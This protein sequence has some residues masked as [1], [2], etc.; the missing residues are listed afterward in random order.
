MTG[1]SIPAYCSEVID[2][3]RERGYE[4]YVVG[5]AVRDLISGKIPHDYDLASSARPEELLKIF[6]EFGFRV[7]AE[8]G[9]KHGT[10][11]VINKGEILEI[12]SFRAD[13][14][15]S[16]SRH[17][18]R[19]S[20]S[21]DIREDVKRRDFTMNA[22][23]LDSEGNVKDLVGGIEDIKNRIIRTVGDPKMRFSE[24]AL[25]IMRAL[26]FASLN[27]FDIDAN[28][29]K[30][31]YECRELLKEI[32]S[33]RIHTELTG[34]LCGRYASKV[35][36]ENVDILSVIIPELKIMEGFD[37]KS[38]YHHLDILEHTLCVL[39]NIPLNQ[40]GRRD[41]TLAYAALMHDMGKPRAFRV[42]EDGKGHMDRHPLY[43]VEISARIAAEL[44]FSNELRDNI[45]EL[46]RFHDVFVK[47]QEKSVNRLMRKLP[48]ELLSKL[49]I[50]QRADILAHSP[51]G[52]KREEI[53][54]SIIAIHDELIN[55][56]VPLSIKDLAING[57]DLINLGVKPG[58]LLGKILNVLLDKVADG[59]INNNCEDLSAFALNYLSEF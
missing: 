22:L 18:D 24:D 35:I 26:R 19:V 33:E 58:P 7:I 2:I 54:D 57:N 17:P 28:T 43:S 36:R 38:D 1:Y 29:S 32:S 34:I 23:Y 44:K 25:R 11:S 46:V 52:R 12:T 40:D 20:F 51:K 13:G 10:V 5:G 31:M 45:M 50:L 59:E 55:R 30:A 56:K 48:A 21:T 49:F 6:Q 4:A 37:Q 41:E 3:I 42:G 53:L 47:P 9:L 8:T 15:Y 27:G 39:D 14:V 16:D